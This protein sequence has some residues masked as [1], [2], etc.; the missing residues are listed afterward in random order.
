MT[1]KPAENK[2]CSS[3]IRYCTMPY[4]KV[5]ILER[6]SP[7]RC[8]NCNMHTNASG[9]LGLLRVKVSINAEVVDQLLM[10]ALTEIQGKDSERY[11]MVAELTKFISKSKGIAIDSMGYS[12]FVARAS[13]LEREGKLESSS[14]ATRNFNSTTLP[15]SKVQGVKCYRIKQQSEGRIIQ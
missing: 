12:S 7:G 4:H 5:E 14:I 3:C 1:S 11:M 13:R 9:S 15:S 8:E 6:L 2:V 10:E